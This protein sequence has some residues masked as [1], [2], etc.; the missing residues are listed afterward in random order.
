MYFEIYSVYKITT[1]DVCCSLRSK[2][3]ADIV[4]SPKVN[5]LHV[6]TEI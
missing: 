1:R 2:Q 4:H 5:T 3:F 6:Y